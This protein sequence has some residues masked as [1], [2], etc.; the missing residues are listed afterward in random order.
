MFV[1]QP[2][3]QP[4][5]ADRMLAS[6]QVLKKLN[7]NDSQRELVLVEQM[8]YFNAFHHKHLHLVQNK[9]FE[10]NKQTN[11]IK[12]ISPL[13]LDSPA[14]VLLGKGVVRSR[15]VYFRGGYPDTCVSVSLTT[16]RV[17]QCVSICCLICMNGSYQSSMAVFTAGHAVSKPSTVLLGKARH[18]R[19]NL[20]WIKQK[21]QLAVCPVL[22]LKV[23]PWK[24]V[25]HVLVPATGILLTCNC[26]F[27]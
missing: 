26:T 20:P 18:R 8:S 14:T 7:T 12:R 2:W 9:A 24:R 16:T 25:A 6:V 1:Q 15:N 4:E 13:Q 11:K 23:T 10:N 17:G 27:K 5:G 3:S 21:K 22:R 19:F